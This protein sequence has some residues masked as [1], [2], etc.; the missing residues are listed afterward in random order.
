MRG[1]RFQ[2]KT[3]ED[4][5][6]RNAEAL[7]E[8]KTVGE[9]R[10]VEV[11]TR[12]EIEE[13]KEELRQLVGASYRDLIESADSILLMKQSCEAVA[14]NIREMESGFASLKKSI[15]FNVSTPA[16]DRE[17]KR[18]EKLY[19][20]G[21]RVKY[22]VDTPEKIWGCLDEHMYL[23][24]AERYLRAR[25]VHSLLTEIGAKEDLLTNFPL[26]RQQWPLIDTFRAQISQRSKDR[27]QEP[28]LRVGDYAVALA[29]NGIIDELN[30]L[31]IFSLFLDSR[32][33]WLRTHLRNLVQ[34]KRNPGGLLNN[35][36]SSEA[37]ADAA[38]M[39]DALC[40]L[41][42]M[43]Q[44]SLCQVGVLFLEVSTGKMP[45]MYST[46]LEAPPGSQLFGG[47]PNPDQEVRL[48]KAHR[49]KLEGSMVSLSGAFITDACLKWLEDCAK[50]IALEAR[51]LIE[52]IR[53][54]HELAKVEGLVREDL[55][56]QEALDE[57]LDWLQET[58]GSG[59]DSPWECLCDLLLKAPRNLWDTLFEG[60]FV[61]RMKT[62]VKSGFAAIN[63]KQLVDD[64]IEATSSPSSAGGDEEQAST[65]VHGDNYGGAHPLR[66]L[67]ANRGSGNYSWRSNSS[68]KEWAGD[69]KFFFT[70]E[71]AKVKD[72]VDDSLKVILQDLVSFLQG[73]HGQMRTD[74]LAPYL[75]EQCFKWVSTVAK[76]LES[77]LTK[78]SESM[79]RAAADILNMS[80]E[81][82]KHSLEG[83]PER[84]G[85][86]AG[87]GG[88]ASRTRILDV[89]NP[90]KV[91]E[92]AL[93]LGRLS[94]ALGQHS[95]SLP[96]LFGSPTSWTAKETPI[97]QGTAK[98]STP[99][100]HRPSWSDANYSSFESPGKW[101]SRRGSGGLGSPAADDGAVKLRELQRNLRRQSI[102]A[103]QMWVRWSTEGLAGTLLRDLHKDEGLST[104]TP[105]KVPILC[106]LCSRS[107]KHH[108]PD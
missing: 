69:A 24:G 53:T 41:V 94:A 87:L 34:E 27:L 38:G 17:R 15:S 48:W 20:L 102:T 100:G 25:E 63:M 33:T 31:D 2:A 12:K 68:E 84:S 18:R 28:G 91:V 19:E 105:L 62:V 45:L 98:S 40:K 70:P 55:K 80:P 35:V 37:D 60:L 66:E 81:N 10:E 21:S 77:R 103:H 43:I 57:T 108:F 74:L 7:F 90:S 6:T 72:K 97:G 4:T 42:H 93:S 86:R 8:A 30:S 101:F 79:L 61:S 5:N 23:E 29:A 83:T 73:P 16:A 67:D 50:E 71:V 58:F 78:L 14:D 96:L 92:Q 11:Q 106:I 39:A 107:F 51:P 22:L 26:L 65:L 99:I 47:I 59:I 9:I 36:D 56:K 44:A 75:H 82:L 88:P 95:V 64:C 49:E 13:K 46:V 104:S 1:G 89:W 52:Q 85:K 54:G 3:N 76:G 32:R